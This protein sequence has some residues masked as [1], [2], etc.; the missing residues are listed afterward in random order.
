MTLDIRSVAPG[1]QD[2][3]AELSLR[4]WEPV[5]ASF[6]E[7]LGKRLFA[8]AYPDWRESQ[9]KEVR[10]CCLREDAGRWVAVLDQQVVG[11]IVV[12][13]QDDPKLAAI[14]L[15]AVDTDQQNQGI[16]TALIDFAMDQ[17]REAGYSRVEVWTGGDVGHAPARRT[18]EKA[19]FTGLPVTEVFPATYVAL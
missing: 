16:G 5:F 4:A 3:V 14:E 12:I 18:Y 13:Y 9:A 1:D 15:L 11:F 6:A 7:I 17:I 10:A 19:G 8:A 2:Q